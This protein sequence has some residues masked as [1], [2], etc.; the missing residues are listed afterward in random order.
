MDVVNRATCE[1]RRSVHTP[2]FPLAQWLHNPDL[3]AV[4]A[5]PRKYWKIVNETVQA[6]DAPSKRPSTL[7]K[8]T[9]PRPLT[10]WPP[11]RAFRSG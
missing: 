8:R 5:L 6:M 1:L 4:A 7:R 2:D 11:R 3:S 9:R 10:V